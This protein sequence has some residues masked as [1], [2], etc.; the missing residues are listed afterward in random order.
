[1]NKIQYIRKITLYKLNY[2]F[3]YLKRKKNLNK[4]RKEEIKA[5]YSIQIL[6]ENNVL[7]ND[8]LYHVL[9]FL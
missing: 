8:C 4:L 7:N 9:S 2:F 1:M 6:S 3:P 5:I